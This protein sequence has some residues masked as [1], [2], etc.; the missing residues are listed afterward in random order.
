MKNRLAKTS[1]V[2]AVAL[3]GAGL[4]TGAQ[5]QSSRPTEWKDWGGDAARLH[6]SALDQITATNV[7]QLKPAW[8]WDSGHLGRSWEITPL[9][10]DGLLFIS[11]N[12]SGDIIAL[13]PETGKQ[14]WRSKPPVPVGKLDRRGLAY[15]A[16]D[17]AM[18]PRIIALW[19]HSMF[20]FDLKTGQ[21]SSD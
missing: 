7:A 15:W 1:L 2:L 20:G 21:Q 11:D 18:K 10:I 12:L 9:L 19:G 4:I 14:A 8:V 6:Y 16:G 5:G 13:E 17:G 3:A